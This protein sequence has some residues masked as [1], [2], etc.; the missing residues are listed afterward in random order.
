MWTVVSYFGGFF[1]PISQN[2]VYQIFFR[3]Y[4]WLY[5]TVLYLTIFCTKLRS[6]Y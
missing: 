2:F 1:L 4:F 6:N 3:F 5:Y